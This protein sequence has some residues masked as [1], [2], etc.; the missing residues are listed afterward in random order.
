MKVLSTLFV[1]FYPVFLLAQQ[2]ASDEAR[3]FLQQTSRE[4][5]HIQPGRSSEPCT[6]CD[7]GGPDTIPVVVHIITLGG[8]IGSYDNPDDAS[9]IAM[10]NNLNSYYNGTYPDSYGLN[11]V[12]G[13]NVGFVFKLAQRTPNC[14]ATNG[15][16]RIN[17]TQNPVYVQ[18]GVSLA[19]SQGITQQ[20]L[21]A[22]SYWDNTK[23]LNIWLVSQIGGGAWG[24]Y[25]F[26]PTGTNTVEDGVVIQYATRNT[27]L[28][29][30][31][32]GHFFN[33]EHTFRGTVG[34]NCAGATG[35]CAQSGD[36]VCDTDPVVQ[37]TNGCNFYGINP[38]TG[39]AYGLMVYNHM[40]Y[41]CGT[42]FT[43]GQLTRMRS[44]L[45]TY[46]SSLL[47]SDGELPPPCA[48][49]PVLFGNFT[50][51]FVK[52]GTAEL[53]WQTIQEINNMGFDVQLSNDGTSF[54]NI[55]FVP[56][57]QNSSQPVS[58]RYTVTRLP[59]GTVFFRLKQTDMDAHVTYSPVAAITNHCSKAGISLYPN[60]AGSRIF[61][62]GL[63]QTQNDI[64]I[65]NALGGIVKYLHNTGQSI[66][67]SDLPPGVYFLIVNDTMKAGFIKSPH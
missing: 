29:P 58:Y 65:I 24:G 32:V 5:R 1:L 7:T 61:I 52:C 11:Q 22:L 41:S 25:S 2:C 6:T 30:H 34:N 54:H 17:G 45:F 38:C 16:N 57:K 9:I 26:F 66:N 13:V 33:L 12:I 40:S 55:A 67:T 19:G 56:G 43:T 28:V 4:Y 27:N 63:D 21:A 48:T 15:I 49:L 18:Y 23:Y 36:Y 14:Q 46:R 47:S 53:M 62:S 8:T 51:S 64:K 39:S 59:E 10:I 20:D 42:I 35:P 44:A 60:P 37:N 31:E 3:A 50:A